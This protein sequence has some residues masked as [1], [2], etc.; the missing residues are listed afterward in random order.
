MDG[1]GL[2]NAGRACLRLLGALGLAWGCLAAHAHG[3]EDHTHGDEARASSPAAQPPLM[4]GDRAQRLPDGSWWVPKSVQRQFGIRTEGVSLGP[5]P[6]AVE[7]PGRVLADPR[8]GGRVQA[9]QAGRIEA[10]PQG[11]PIL[12]TRVRK[13]QI[14]AY[15]RP[16]AASLDR[17]NQQA[18]L[19]EVSS[20]YRQAERRVQR[21]EQLEGAIAAKEIESARLERDALRQRQAAL[22][23]SVQSAEPLVAPVSGVIS[24]S[25]V[26][27]GQVVEARDPVFEVLDPARLVVEA[28]VR[29]PRQA[30]GVTS[31]SAMQG[32][33]RIALQWLGAGRQLRDQA[34]PVLFRV[35][36][37]QGSLLVGQSIKVTAQLAGT[38][39]GFAVPRR[40]L[41]RNGANE[42]VVWVHRQAEVFV[43]RR[44]RP[45]PLD[46]QGVVVS[47]GLADGDRVVVEGASL[48]AQLR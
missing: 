40:A 25:M 47:D 21:Y 41:T 24:A 33:D 6:A 13:G 37:G 15:L 14:L 3:G 4:A 9:S 39:K 12:G 35:M 22:A 2:G 7:W 44:V 48:L 16:I 11:L 18:A 43:P 8:A 23:A 45:M 10:G 5:Q 27:L 36:S 34:M 26:T 20:Q 17:G 31:A 30:E 32:Q 19:A 29:E 46:A 1:H 42:V 28:L 38:Q